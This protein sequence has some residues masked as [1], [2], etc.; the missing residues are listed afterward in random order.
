MLI[1]GVD[2]ALHFALAGE[3]LAVLGIVPVVGGV[4]VGVGLEAPVPNVLA[5]AVA[6]LRRDVELALGADERAIGDAGAAGFAEDLFTT[7]RAIRQVAFQEGNGL[8]DGF[9]G[10]TPGSQND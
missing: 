6:L 2:E 7:G 3:E 1:D 10:A 9:T 5:V 8:G 4:F